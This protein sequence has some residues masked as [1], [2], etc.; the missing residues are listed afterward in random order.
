MLFR[1]AS[2]PLGGT[3]FVSYLSLTN[4]HRY[5]MRLYRLD[6]AKAELSTKALATD[7]KENR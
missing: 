6:T 5:I 4:H 7:K 3:F 2:A 1:G